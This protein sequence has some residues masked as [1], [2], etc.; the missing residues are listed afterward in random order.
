MKYWRLLY[1]RTPKIRDARGAVKPASIAS[2]ERI[3]LGGIE[4]TILLRGHDRS[5]PLLLILHGGPGG[6]AMPLVHEFSSQLEE[7]FVVVN[8]DQ[9]GAGKS[10]A[11]DIPESSMTVDQFVR[12]CRDLVSYLCERFQQRK[13]YLA[14]HSW[15]TQIGVLTVQRH[16]ELFH[17]Y[18]G[19]AQVVNVRRA[20][21]ISLQ[22]AL[23]GARR[24]GDRMA[25]DRLVRLKPPGY[26]GSVKDLLFQRECVARY[27]GTFSN[28][29]V[30]KALFRK[31]FQS[32]EY[33]LGD[34]LKLK[35]G[36]HWS[37]STMWEQGLDW[38]L[39]QQVPVLEVPAYFLHGR[40]DRVT[41]SELVQEYFDL[42]Q[43]PR[44]ALIWFEHSGHCPLFEE[45]GRFQRV[46]IER[47]L[48]DVDSAP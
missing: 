12:D 36:S 15:G 8:W 7:H 2:L 38:D 3:R 25:E 30:D 28:Q 10:Y 24:A 41:P 27:G 46:L 26:D 32:H 47:I 4:Q 21:S 44:K 29:A 16:P 17:A 37:L 31:Y 18:I 42:L 33:S 5:L 1:S 35:K 39:L 20:E 43:A 40:C 22:F 9:R 19:I 45:A 23:E 11:P 13:I 14:G 6:T 48:R 34:L